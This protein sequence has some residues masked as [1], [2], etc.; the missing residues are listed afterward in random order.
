MFYHH[1]EHAILAT[2]PNSPQCKRV[3]PV[4]FSRCVSYQKGPISC[5]SKFFIHFFP[6]GREKNRRQ[7]SPRRFDGSRV[8]FFKGIFRINTPVT[9]D[10]S[11]QKI[12]MPKGLP[13]YSPQK[14]KK[15]KKKNAQT[16]NATSLHLTLILR[17]L[18]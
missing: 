12:M 15:K 11:A 8:M 1:P 13:L 18:V 17:V 10:K 6:E 2:C 3:I 4:H 16:K 9:L 14:K 5:V 7:C